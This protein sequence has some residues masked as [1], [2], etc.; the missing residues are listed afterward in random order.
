MATNLSRNAAESSLQRSDSPA[1]QR[2]L[3]E[4]IVDGIICK[5]DSFFVVSTVHT[6]REKPI[7]EESKFR[8]LTINGESYGK[9]AD[10]VFDEIPERDSLPDPPPNKYR[11]N[12]FQR[13]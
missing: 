2:I 9:N 8:N 6:S 13:I 4:A 5:M 1:S 3:G 10:K 7:S 11:G 12:S